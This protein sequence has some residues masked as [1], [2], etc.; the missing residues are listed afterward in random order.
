MPPQPRSPARGHAAALTP[1]TRSLGLAAL[2]RAP[3]MM[4]MPRSRSAGV[5]R[6]AAPPSPSAL[7]PPAGEAKA[8]ELGR[9][10]VRDISAEASSA[11]AA[12][13]CIG[14]PL[15][16]VLCFGDRLELPPGACPPGCPALIEFSRVLHAEFSGAKRRVRLRLVPRDGDGRAALCVR[17]ELDAAADVA[18]FQRV[19]WPLL[20]RAGPR[21]AG[22]DARPSLVFFHA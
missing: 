6:R 1:P 12:P 3:A 17:L 20:T 15:A 4:M 8:A 18:A 9:F 7:P 10:R 14:R 11:P 5:L 2:P 22:D 19:A 21:A 16:T 13:L